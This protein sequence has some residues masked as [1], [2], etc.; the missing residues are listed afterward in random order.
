MDIISPNL[1]AYLIIMS[2]SLFIFI[3]YFIIKSKLLFKDFTVWI[4]FLL[5]LIILALLPD[6]ATYASKLL[7]IQ[8]VAITAIISVNLFMLFMLMLLYAR[9]SM[10]NEKL[11]SLV[12]EI[13]IKDFENSAIIQELIQKRKKK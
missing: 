12:Q 2:V 11:T 1:R 6:V 4:P 9:L 13:G 10:V 3:L 8:T 7:S 5:Y